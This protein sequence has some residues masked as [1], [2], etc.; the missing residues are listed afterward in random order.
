[1]DDDDEEGSEDDDDGTVLA[2]GSGPSGPIGLRRSELIDVEAG[3]VDGPPRLPSDALVC[4]PTERMHLITLYRLSGVGQVHELWG[5]CC[6][7]F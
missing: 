4:V 6:V 1:M 2:L 3:E 7:V 5:A